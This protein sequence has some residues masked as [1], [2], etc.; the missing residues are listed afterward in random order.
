MGITCSQCT[1]CFHASCAKLRPTETKQTKSTLWFCINCLK[2]PLGRCIKTLMQKYESLFALAEES[3]T[4]R[5]SA[6][7]NKIIELE[8]PNSTTPSPNPRPKKRQKQGLSNSFIGTTGSFPIHP[9]E[10]EMDRPE[11]NPMEAVNHIPEP[12]SEPTTSQHM[13]K[14]WANIACHSAAPVVKAVSINRKQLHPSTTQTSIPKPTKTPVRNSL[15]I[16]CTNIPEPSSTTLQLRAAE[17]RTKWSNLC[18][19]LGIALIPQSIIRLS[20][21]HTSPNYNDPR[22]MRVTLSTS[23][24]VETQ[25]HSSRSQIFPEPSHSICARCT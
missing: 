5:F 2:T 9:A 6:M 24:D 10:I 21:K 19:T 25:T 15:S 17:E 7:E 16:I 13:K 8:K 20:R 1:R 22:L 18:Q 3:I 14:T 23:E 11:Q 12:P 4:T